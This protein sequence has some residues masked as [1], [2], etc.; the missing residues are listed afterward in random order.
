MPAKSLMDERDR[1]LMWRYEYVLA[2]IYGVPHLVRPDSLVPRSGT[3]FIRDKGS[4]L[5]V[6]KAKQGM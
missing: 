6:G 1:Y 4:G 2:S 3:V 5:L